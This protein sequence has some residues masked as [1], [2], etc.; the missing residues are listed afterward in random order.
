MFN[1]NYYKEQRMNNDAK[2]I[3]AYDLTILLIMIA[4]LIFIGTIII[5][6]VKE[7]LF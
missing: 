3:I 5:E 1:I 2:K 7:K 6:L 4:P